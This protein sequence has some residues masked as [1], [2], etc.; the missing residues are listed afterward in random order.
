MTGRWTVA[1]PGAPEAGLRLFCFAHAGGGPTLFRSW[2]REFGQDVDIRPILLP[3]REARAREQPFRRMTDIIGPMC[4]GLLPS[5]DRPFALFGHSLGAVLA[6]E[7]A[8]EFAARGWGEPRHLVVSARRAPHLPS[9]RA[10]LHDLP[11]DQFTAAVAGMGG[12]PAEVLAHPGLLNAFAPGL[13]ADF[14]VNE[15]YTPLPGGL[16][17][18]PVSAVVGRS[19]SEVDPDEMAGWR[20]T[21]RGGFDLRVVD[22]GHFYLKEDPGELLAL[23]RERL[24]VPAPT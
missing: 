12:T 2:Q 20:D 4:D 19:D 6:Y 21:T 18:C 10:R 3:G 22:G 24:G 1:A 8:R 15:T 11:Q 23:I 9:R 17:A 7:A 16:L 5:L 14:E 13:R